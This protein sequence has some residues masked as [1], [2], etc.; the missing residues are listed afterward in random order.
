MIL[1][2]K[3]FYWRRF[4]RSKKNEIWRRKSEAGKNSFGL[5]KVGSNPLLRERLV[6]VEYKN[7]WKLLENSSA[8]ARGEA[9]SEAG[10]K[11]L[12]DLDS[13]QDSMVQS[14]VS[15]H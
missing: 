6:F 10:N 11:L 9:P 1:Q 4:L 2:N 13:N 8:E 14:H 3:N 7:P 15:Y 12:R 5:K